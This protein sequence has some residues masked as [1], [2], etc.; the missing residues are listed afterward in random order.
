M[1]LIARKTHTT[2]WPAIWGVER[3]KEVR[4]DQVCSS[5]NLAHK[6]PPLAIKVSTLHACSQHLRFPHPEFSPVHQQTA[7]NPGLVIG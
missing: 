4:S 3:A 2:L 1:R 7:A 5:T 6:L